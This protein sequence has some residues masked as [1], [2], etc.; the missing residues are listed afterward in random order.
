MGFK[1][2][3]G[4]AMKSIFGTFSSEMFEVNQSKI[5]QNVIDNN[6]LHNFN[7]TGITALEDITIPK[8]GNVAERVIKKGQKISARNADELSMLLDVNNVGK[9]NFGEGDVAVKRQANLISS[10]TDYMN[11]HS[12][13]GGAGRDYFD[14]DGTALDVRAMTLAGREGKDTIGFSRTMS[15]YFGDAE[16]GSA[17][18][19]AAGVAYAGVNVAG[20]Y[21]GGGELTTNAQGERDIAGIPFF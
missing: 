11:Y 6:I 16:Y 21:L 8:N 18:L 15:G 2:S 7:K 19:K 4:S 12:A 20:R 9:Y 17:R 1:S 10:R 14:M 5:L 13:K 3:V